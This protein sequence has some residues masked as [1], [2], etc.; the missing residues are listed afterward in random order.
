MAKSVDDY[1]N[2][3]D[4]SFKGYTPSDEVLKYVNF[5]QL[6]SGGELENTT[7]QVHLK[8][9]EALFQKG[10]NSAIL[11]HRGIAKTTIAVEFMILYIAAFGTFPN[12]GKVEFLIYV[13]DSI[14]NGV[15]S[16]RKNIEHRYN[17][18]EYLQKLIP[19]VNI[20]YLD[21]NGD[22]FSSSAGRKFTDVRME[23]VNLRGDK[24]AVRLYGAK[25]G[26]RGAK[27]YG[28]RP[29]VAI[30]DD[31]LSDEDARSETCI[32]NIEDTIHK[33]VKF[34]LNPN[35][36]K[37]IWIGTPFNA[38]DPL[39]KIVESG[40]W[41]V[42]C[43]PICEKFP[44]SKD[45]FRGSWEERFSY[46][47]VKKSYEE[48]LAIGK[49]DS[50]MGELMLR[51]TSSEE[52]LIEAKDIVWFDKKLVL[53]NKTNFN[54]YITT[55]IA[56]S[57]KSSS[58][59][60][61]ISVWAYSNN[62]D[63]LLVDGFCKQCE[64][65]LFIDELFRFVAEYSPLGVGIEVSGQQGGFISWIKSE[66]IKRNVFFNLLSSNNGNSEGIRP[67]KD[68]FS[69]LVLFL[70]RFK[71]NKIWFAKELKD[72]KWHMEFEDERSKA[73]KKGLK[74]KHDDVLDTI[75]ML[76]SFEAYKPSAIRDENYED[77]S[78]INIKNTIF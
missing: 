78:L 47:Y 34:A 7:P 48:A 37:M 21:E 8:M 69:R 74:S 56:T 24:L 26:V 9:I 44:C 77:E 25:T 61:V 75:S 17:N 14:E 12:L 30:I 63:F 5:I 76:G 52:L 10:L 38:K 45:E 15:K 54:F 33:A 65:S 28:K 50:F 4:Y 35:N 11:S 27:E 6:A 40:A 13:G 22:E 32:K 41:A 64:M 23:F 51:I 53:E 42:A 19:N 68:K 55:D 3:V 20:K 72:S 1:L 62:G 59:Y 43:Y 31:I 2:E 57:V 58:D 67:I 73:T 60:S 29:R 18:S 49:L 46:E 39:Y 16:L 36:S 66:M 70:P 71:T